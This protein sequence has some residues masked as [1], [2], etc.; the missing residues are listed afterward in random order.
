MSDNI[1]RRTTHVIASPQ[2]R[3]AK[4]RQ[5]A[6]KPDR[7]NIVT[8]DWLYDSLSQWQRVS[9]EKYRIH[10][11]VAENGEKPVNLNG[12]PFD[13]L[14]EA[15]ALSSS[16][17]EAALTEEEGDALS[18]SA[19]SIGANDSQERAELEQ[20]MP[21]LSR[22]DSSPNEETNEDWEGMNDELAD[23]LGSDV[24]DDSESSDVESTKSVDS[25]STVTS[26]SSAQKRKRENGTLHPT[27]DDES[28]ASQSGSKLQ[29]RKR[30]ALARTSSLT[31]IAAL[32]TPTPGPGPLRDPSAEKEEEEEGDEEEDLDAALAAELEA[33]MLRQAEEEDSA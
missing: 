29:R 18:G 7:I 22:E 32:A 24:E 5:A 30:M 23:F 10:S 31:N 15:T 19:P 2:R 1:T 4:V 6:K 26:P 13:G 3:T 16:D 9:E 11:E 25:A 28:D 20:Y 33:E 14:D 8:Q 27:D 17:E 21:S 12:S